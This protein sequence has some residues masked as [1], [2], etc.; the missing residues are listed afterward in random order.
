[1]KRLRFLTALITSALL[2]SCASP[3]QAQMSS[4]YNSYM[5][6]QI[7]QR[8]YNREMARLQAN[9]AGWQQQQANDVAMGVG[10]A[11]VALGTAAIIDNNSHHGHYYGHG[12]Y[13][14][15]GHR[16]HVNIHH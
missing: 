4:L 14:G 2:V 11:A 6:G 13:H 8:E 10:I 15:H 3:Y 12:H 9:D 16:R 5:A 1:M 7:S